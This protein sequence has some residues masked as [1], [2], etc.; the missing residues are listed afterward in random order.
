MRRISRVP[1]P[2]RV[3]VLELLPRNVDHWEL[4]GARPVPFRKINPCPVATY[5][6]PEASIVRP[7]YKTLERKRKG[8]SSGASSKDQKTSP[9]SWSRPRNIPALSTW[10][11]SPLDAMTGVVTSFKGPTGLDQCK[12]PSGRIFQ[13]VP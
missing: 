13:I 12:E 1:E 2:R 11:I 10:K 9:V 6:S 3:P 7:E 8:G 4:F 5:K